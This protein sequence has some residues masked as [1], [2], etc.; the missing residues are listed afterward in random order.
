M[1]LETGQIL[2]LLIS[3]QAVGLSEVELRFTGE[4]LQRVIRKRFGRQIDLEGRSRDWLAPPTAI[5][6][7]FY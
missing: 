1:T 4:E 7:K 6:P 5:L 2:E 3:E